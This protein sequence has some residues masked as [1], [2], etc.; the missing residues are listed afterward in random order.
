MTLGFGSLLF[1]VIFI[2]SGLQNLSVIDVILGR[3]APPHGGLD[4]GG[5]TANTPSGPTTL[6]DVVQDSLDPHKVG[7]MVARIKREHPELHAGIRHVVAQILVKFPALRITST[8]GGTHAK[9]SYH[10]KGRAADLGGDPATMRV[11]AQWIRTH[12]QPVLTEGIHNPGLSVKNHRL[13]QPDF[14]TNTVWL[15]HINHIHVAV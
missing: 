2:Y 7:A 12:L 10:Y 5:G 9:D 4:G 1:G 3:P 6:D 13:V 14:W 11:A 15:Q 8:T